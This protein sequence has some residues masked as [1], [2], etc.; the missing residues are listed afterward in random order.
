[1]EKSLKL[2]VFTFLILLSACSD[3]LVKKEKLNN[4]KFSQ[5]SVTSEVTPTS[6]PNKYKVVL[7]WNPT[8]DVLMVTRSG[9]LQKKLDAATNE[10]S[11]L[12]DGGQTYEYKF[13]TYQDGKSQTVQLM[14]VNVQ[15]PVDYVLTGERLLTGDLIMSA[16]RIFI[17]KDS[18]VRS[19]KYRV[20][21][22][23][24]ELIAEGGKFQSFAPGELGDDEAQ[25]IVDSGGN[26]TIMT[27]S[28]VG[29]LNF[30]MRGA[31]GFF[32]KGGDGG[33]LTVKAKRGE[34]LRINLDLGASVG[35]YGGYGFSKAGPG[36]VTTSCIV[37]SGEGECL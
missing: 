36:S 31:R 5:E 22:T 11:D 16:N 24:K 1:M 33:K 21:L 2:S 32:M 35:S 30:S 19:R 18:F 17:R 26:I 15:V 28:A 8:S 34:T 20:I 12:L 13:E 29:E 23:S 7:K 14:K 10:T 9:A 4:A 37:L 27:D 3:E 6:M 25:G